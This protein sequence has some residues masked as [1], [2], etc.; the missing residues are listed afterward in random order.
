[1]KRKAKQRGEKPKTGGMLIA[2]AV[3]VFV[4]LL[5]LRMIAFVGGHS[6][7]HF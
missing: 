7:H 2:F 1:M 3:A 4:L 5:L 6:R